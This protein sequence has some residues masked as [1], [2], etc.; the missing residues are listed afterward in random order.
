[1]NRGHL[2][3]ARSRSDL[4]STRGGV[5]I[6]WGTLSSE[7]VNRGERPSC[8]PESGSLCC[9]GSI[10]LIGPEGMRAATFTARSQMACCFLS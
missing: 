9:V 1:M 5:F 3:P 6:A 2:G 7:L 10:W 4:A 8:R